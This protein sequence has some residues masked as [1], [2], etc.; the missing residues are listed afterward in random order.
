LMRKFPNLAAF[1][2]PQ[3]SHADLY[4][5]ITPVNSFRVVFRMYFGADLATLP[6]RNYVFRS[7]RRL[8]DFT[9]VTERVSALMSG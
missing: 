6:D 5:T 9:E 4:P 1:Y 8:Y 3:A 7:T 2:L